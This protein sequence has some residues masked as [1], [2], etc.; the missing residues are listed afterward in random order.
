MSTKCRSTVEARNLSIVQGA[1]CGTVLLYAGAME[2]DPTIEN[3]FEAPA[4]K[5]ASGKETS[6][7]DIKAAS[8]AEPKWGM[9][10]FAAMFAKRP[11]GGLAQAK[12][13]SDHFSA[14]ALIHS[15]SMASSGVF[16]G[17]RM[18]PH[19]CGTPYRTDVACHA[20]MWH[21][22]M[23]SSLVAA[24]RVGHASSRATVMSAHSA[25]SRLL[26]Q[27]I[28]QARQVGQRRSL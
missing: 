22:T 21:A 28:A 6:N 24:G 8:V 20:A 13:G 11:N 27:H 10:G 5:A 2:E 18:Q 3:I 14:A 19:A 15:R 17:L 1:G 9:R 23:L 16:D 25:T 4:A 7:V 12:R 26:Q